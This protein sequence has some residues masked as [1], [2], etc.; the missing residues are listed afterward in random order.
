MKCNCLILTV[1]LVSCVL[2]LQIGCQEH[3]SMTLKSKTA[4]KSSKPAISPAKTE[5]ASQVDEPAPK[6]T[7]D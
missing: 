6:I 3:V 1:F 2:L 4:A 7:V 5:A